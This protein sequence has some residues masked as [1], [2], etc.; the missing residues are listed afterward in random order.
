MQETACADDDDD[1]ILCPSVSKAPQN[2]RLVTRLI[3][4]HFNN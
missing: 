2:E 1:I 4:K 3:I